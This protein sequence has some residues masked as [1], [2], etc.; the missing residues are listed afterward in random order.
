[1]LT[2]T[3]RLPTIFRISSFVFS[4]RKKL[5]QVMNNL[6]VNDDW[7]YIFG[8]TVSLNTSVRSVSEKC[9]SNIQNGGSWLCVV[10]DS[11]DHILSVWDWQREERLAEV[12]VSAIQDRYWTDILSMSSLHVNK[13]RAETNWFPFCASSWLFFLCPHSAP[14]SQSLLLIST[15][16]MPI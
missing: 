15:R 5:L 7:V 11:N 2:S 8:W 13:R 1:M 4:R 10:D 3:V 9:L 16:Q 12:K 14:T 6:W